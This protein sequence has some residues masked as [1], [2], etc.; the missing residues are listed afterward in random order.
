MIVVYYIIIVERTRRKKPLRIKY[1]LLPTSMFCSRRDL[2]TNTNNGVLSFGHA[3][4]F[5]PSNADNDGSYS[6]NRRIWN[7]TSYIYSDNMKW[8][9]KTT[10]PVQIATVNQKKKWMNSTD[11][12]SST[13]LEKKKSQTIGKTSLNKQGDAISFKAGDR[14]NERDANRALWRTRNTI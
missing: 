11:R 6:M 9:Y 13:A 3:M 12:D 10:N 8:V 7:G 1:Y 14:V 2:S 5:K 4:P